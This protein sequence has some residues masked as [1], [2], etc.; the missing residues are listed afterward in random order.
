MF[1]PELLE[2][3][4]VGGA[5]GRSYLQYVDSTNLMLLLLLGSA[6]TIFITAPL[7]NRWNT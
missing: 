4:I 3:I 6:F 1:S 5:C 7:T 2:G